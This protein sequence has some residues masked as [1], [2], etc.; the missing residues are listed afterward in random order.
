RDV[1]AP[2]P[3]AS[4]TL[5]L[6]LCGSGR[7]VLR[8]LGARTDD[9]GWSEQDRDQADEPDRGNQHRQRE[10]PPAVGDEHI[11]HT[12][13]ADDETMP[14]CGRTRDTG[15]NEDERRHGESHEQH[16]QDGLPHL[17]GDP[18]AHQLEDHQRTRCPMPGQR[19][20]LDLCSAVGAL[21]PRPGSGAH[22]SSDQQTRAAATASTSVNGTATYGT[23]SGAD[24]R[25][26]RSVRA[27]PVHA[28]TGSTTADPVSSTEAAVLA[29]EASPTSNTRNATPAAIS[30][31]AVRIQAR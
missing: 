1:T 17:G 9:V 4:A 11:P 20:A 27:H 22:V 13:L 2:T 25:R 30:A 7:R 12:V 31:S 16:G 15:H 21:A 8:R 5:P 19:G 23:G 26:L 24:C 3:T 10:R 18:S 14:R 28:S 6:L 29:A